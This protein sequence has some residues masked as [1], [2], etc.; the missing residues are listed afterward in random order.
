MRTRLGNI[1]CLEGGRGGTDRAACSFSLP[2]GCSGIHAHRD[3]GM[4]EYAG[5]PA[6]GTEG[7][8]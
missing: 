2:W 6:V 8:T 3:T 7:E 4:G 5:Q 1:V